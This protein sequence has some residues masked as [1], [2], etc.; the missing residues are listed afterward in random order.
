MMWLVLYLYGKYQ[1]HHP[2]VTSGFGTSMAV[3]SP[4]A[5]AFFIAVSRTMDYHHNFDDII[6]GNLAIVCE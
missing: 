2:E 5:V 4:L 6:G 1:V 3:S